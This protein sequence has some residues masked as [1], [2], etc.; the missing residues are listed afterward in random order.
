[1]ESLWVKKPIARKNK[2]NK[3]IVFMLLLPEYL[4]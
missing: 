1:M 4:Q 2:K 3:K